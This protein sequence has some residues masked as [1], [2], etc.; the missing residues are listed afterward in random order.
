MAVDARM[1]EKHKREWMTP[2]EIAEQYGVSRDTVYRMIRE[3]GLE[4]TRF[5]S[6]WRIN[7]ETLKKWLETH[8]KG[9]LEAP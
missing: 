7:K 2:L 1:Q 4:A 8:T 5:G 6:Q 9:E 3:Q